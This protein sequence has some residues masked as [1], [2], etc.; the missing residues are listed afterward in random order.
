[1]LKEAPEYDCW[2]PLG[3]VLSAAPSPLPHTCVFEQQAQD[4]EPPMPEM[5]GQDPPE[6]GPQE[7]ALEAERLERGWDTSLMRKCVLPRVTSP[8]TLLTDAES[9]PLTV[10]AVHNCFAQLNLHIPPRAA[11]TSDETRYALIAGTTRVVK[12]RKTPGSGRRSSG[13]KPIWP[14]QAGPKPGRSWGTSSWRKP[15][16]LWGTFVL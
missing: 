5:E 14:P 13:R 11:R 12:Q 10:P 8:W 7:A 6:K 16:K 9:T 4:P 2:H 15:S 3:S 1:M